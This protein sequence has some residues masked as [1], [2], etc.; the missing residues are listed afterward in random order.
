MQLPFIQKKSYKRKTLFTS[1]EED[2]DAWKI[3]KDRLENYADKIGA[4]LI[5]LPKS[6]WKNP[7]WA[8]FD[9]LEYSAKKGKE[10]D[11]FGWIDYDIIVTKDA[12][13]IFDYDDKFFVVRHPGWHT[14]YNEYCEDDTKRHLSWK[15]IHSFYGVPNIY[16]YPVTALSRWTPVTV[17]RIVP[18]I[19]DFEEHLPKR[20][21]DQEILAI[22]AYH[23]STPYYYF[24]ETLHG[25]PQQY[26]H[27]KNKF[28]HA[29]G[30]S[31]KGDS[32]HNKGHPSSYRTKLEN[33]VYFERLVEAME[34]KKYN[35]ETLELSLVKQDMKKL[36][37]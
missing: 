24:D 3:T 22:A 20:A 36:Y 25:V 18:F 23:T 5:N 26:D 12:P 9:A 14:V 35:L 31:L 16:P 28:F 8:F 6:K 10:G 15:K 1:A 4:S 13:D 27:K 2:W 37:G 17:N 7:Q 34:L 29:W 33:L 11:V 30:G 32:D 19:K 21:G